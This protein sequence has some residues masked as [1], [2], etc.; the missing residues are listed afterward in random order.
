MF[1]FKTLSIQLSYHDQNMNSNSPTISFKSVTDA[2]LDNSKPF[3]PKYLH[4]FSDINPIDLK[5]LSGIWPQVDADR[6]YALLKDL[7]DLQ[8]SDTLL[9]HEEIARLA[10]Q[11]ENPK[12]RSQAIKLLWEYDDFHL[13]PI[14]SHM[15]QHDDDICVRASAASALGK[16]VLMGEREEIPTSMLNEIIQLLFRI[17]SED[18]NDLLCRAALESLSYSSDE[19]VTPLIKD[20]L[21]KED[22]EWLTSA[23]VAMGRNLDTC[24]EKPVISFLNHKNPQVQITAIQSAGELEIKNAR[25]LLINLIHEQSIDSDTLRETIW[26]LS[27]IGGEETREVLE[28]MLEKSEDNDEIDMLED[29][30]ENFTF[31]EDMHSFDIFNGKNGDEP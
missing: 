22:T 10:L 15:L 31:T 14:F 1:L 19:R 26:A 30:L 20:A 6:R 2:L 13:V 5:T 24:W 25:Q 16:Y 7:Q 8:E 21:K 18:A 3:S 12:V 29:A 27:K 17:I 23:L 9:S 4:Y 28:D 11:D